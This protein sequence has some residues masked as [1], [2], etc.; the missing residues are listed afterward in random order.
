MTAAERKAY[1]Y[2]IKQTVRNNLILLFKREQN[3]KKIIA[4]ECGVKA[5]SIS[6]W[7]SPNF[8]IQLPG[9]EYLK[10]IAAHYH[11]TVDWILSDHTIDDVLGRVST[12]A[13][14]VISLIPL[15][16]NN[17]I[18]PIDIK[19]PILRF[20]CEDYKSTFRKIMPE[21]E[22]MKWISDVME[23]YNVPLPTMKNM[24]SQFF[25]ALMK[26]KNI[27][28]F[29][30]KFDEYANIARIIGDKRRMNYYH[31]APLEGPLDQEEEEE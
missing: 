6:R 4:D 12:Y 31:T 17:T 8:D 18:K 2:V 10:I 23:H 19:D 14:A 30:N 29:R 27:E 1:Q 20:L 24:R 15:L 7:I 9:P 16:K 11:V 22:K 26:D 25:D 3:A 13:D 28:H 5:S 21:S